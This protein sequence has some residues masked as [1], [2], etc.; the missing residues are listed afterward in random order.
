MAITEIKTAIDGRVTVENS[1]GSVET[2]YP[3]LQ[4]AGVIVSPAAQMAVR[5]AAGFTR[6]A[7]QLALRYISY[8]A[9]LAPSF[10]GYTFRQIFQL[11]FTGRVLVRAVWET[12]ATTPVNR[13]P[14]FAAGRTFELNPTDATGAAAAWQVG[15]AVTPP[16]ATTGIAGWARAKSAWVLL[17]V[18]APTDG[19]QGG[20]VFVNTLYAA[21]DRCIVGNAS[22]PVNDWT[23]HINPLLP[24]MKYGG[25]TANG[26]FTTTNQ[27]AF[28][29]P[30]N[31]NFHPAWIEVV[32]ANE[33]FWGVNIGD[34]TS[35]ALGTGT[36]SVQPYNYNW[37]HIGAHDRLQAG[38]PV[39]VSNFAHEG[40]VNDVHMGVPDSTGRL[41]WLINDTDFKPSFVVLQPFS[42]NSSGAGFD[43]A[44]VNTSIT[45]TLL[46]CKRLRDAGIRPILR[47]V[48]PVSGLSAGRETNRQAGNTTIRNSGELVFDLDAIVRDPANNSQILPAYQMDGT[49]LN[50]AGNE[51]GARHPTLGFASLLARIGI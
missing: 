11:P 30:L 37:A 39:H 43:T 35:Q 5:G 40:S 22:R 23:S 47:T 18:P 34:S 21:A 2:G 33:V 8:A 27:G 45:N 36:P 31:Q 1:D 32:P 50:S 44:A 48:A 16:A 7:G 51:A 38:R 4:D 28:P 26:D 41:T 13:T 19:G 42:V 12:D 24:S 46:W 25:Y 6:P 15:A 10:G 3:I 17:D 29:T 9:T 14:S 20:Y 49:H